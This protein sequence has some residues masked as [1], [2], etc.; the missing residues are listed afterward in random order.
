VCAF[1]LSPPPFNNHTTR[2][3]AITDPAKWA[4]ESFQYVRTDVYNFN[5]TSGTPPARP[6][7]RSSRAVI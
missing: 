7:P 5:P 6:P 1:S 3:A 2:Y 4:N